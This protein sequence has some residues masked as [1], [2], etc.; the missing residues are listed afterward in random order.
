MHDLRR[1]FVAY[2]RLSKAVAFCECVDS[3]A[4]KKH[5]GDP[6]EPVAPWLTREPRLTAQSPSNPY[7]LNPFHN[8]HCVIEGL[9]TICHEFESRL[10]HALAYRPRNA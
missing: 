6:V 10:I 1:S 2:C 9:V 5:R 4:G 7:G 8:R 3:A